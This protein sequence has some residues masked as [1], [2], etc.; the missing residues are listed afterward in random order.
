MIRL[1]SGSGPSPWL[2]TAPQGLLKYRGQI[3]LYCF[4]PLQL[5]SALYLVKNMKSSHLTLGQPQA[6]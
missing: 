3:S 5:L 4:Y 6:Q 2:P 1:V